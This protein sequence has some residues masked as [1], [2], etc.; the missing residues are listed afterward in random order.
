[1]APVNTTRLC[2]SKSR[3]RELIGPLIA[4]NAGVPFNLIELICSLNL[5]GNNA[6]KL[7]QLSQ[8]LAGSETGMKGISEMKSVFTYLD[9]L[10]LST[11]VQLDLT[12]ARGLNYY[13]G[14]IIEVKATDVP[15]G[16]ISGG[17]RYDDLT[18]IFGLPEVSGVGISYGADRIYDVL[19]ELNL[20]PAEAEQA[21]KVL[22]V[23]FGGAEEI[24]SLKFLQKLQQA[25]VPSEMYP[26]AAKMKKQ[27]GYA[28]T[29]KIPYTVIIGSNEAAS[30]EY[31]LKN[32]LTG[33]QGLYSP[34]T[35]IRMIK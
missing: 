29:K 16:S 23:N 17:G 22:I 15:M 1:M 18:G 9:E 13:T 5:E 24:T 26:E 28:D 3:A 6:Q 35:I 11:S 4:F 34:D 33:E 2:F 19:N 31:Q 12:L 27:F 30:G 7:E 14:A 32:M 8:I 20:F 21:T 10:S 25:G